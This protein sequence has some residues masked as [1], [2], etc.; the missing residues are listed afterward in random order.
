MIYVYAH[1]VACKL[2][3][4]ETI[5]ILQLHNAIAQLVQSA[6]HLATHECGIG[7]GVGVTTLWDLQLGRLIF[8]RRSELLEWQRLLVLLMVDLVL[9]LLLMLMLLLCLL[10]GIQRLNSGPP[11]I[12]HI[13]RWWRCIGILLERRIG[14]GFQIRAICIDTA[15][16]LLRI[17]N[18]GVQIIQIRFGTAGHAWWWLLWR[19]RRLIETVVHSVIDSVIALHAVIGCAKCTRAKQIIIG[20]MHCSI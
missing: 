14:A 7:F 5:N 19:H 2:L 13:L 15:L 16:R 9:I 20:K 1:I 8:E 4:E 6:R 12:G 18:H 3:L 17:L 11:A 10:T